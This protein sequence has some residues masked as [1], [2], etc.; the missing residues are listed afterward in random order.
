MSERVDYYTQRGS[1]AQTPNNWNPYQPL[2]M[3]VVLLVGIFLGSSLGKGDLFEFA[4]SDTQSNPSKLVEVI[5]RI[6]N[7]YVDSVQKRELIDNAINSILEDLD[8]HSFYISPEEFASMNE[9]MQGGFE[10]IGVEFMIED[11]TLIVVNPLTGGPSERAGILPGDRIVL[12]NDSAISGTDI[13]NAVVMKRLKGPSGSTVKLEIDRPGEVERYTF[14]IV[15]ERIPIHSVVAQFMENEEI[16]YIKITQFAA[17]TYEE[18]IGA[19][20]DLKE[21]GM[22]K[23]VIDLRSNGGGYLDAATNIVEEFLDKGE[24]IVYTEGRSQGRMSTYSKRKGRLRDVEVAVLMN[25][26]SASASEVVAGALQDHDRSI[27]V[28]RRSFG[29][30]LVQ[31]Q[32][33]MGDASALRIT[34]AR[35]Y[36]PSGRCIQKPYGDGIDYEDDYHQR[37]ESGELMHADS[38]QVTDSL[39][40]TT[41]GG[42]LVY[43]GGG[44][45]PD[46]FVAL[47]TTGSS[48]Y[49]GELS[50]AGVLRSFTLQYVNEHRADWSSTFPNM[51]AFDRG[52][53]ITPRIEAALDELA[54]A[55]DITPAP[56]TT[57]ARQEL[58]LR[59]KAL[60]AKHLF[61]ENAYYYVLRNRDR[62]YMKAVDVL[63]DYTTYFNESLARNQQ[64]S[65]PVN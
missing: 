40:Y 3:A 32:Y 7:H 29:K 59:L 18:F 53:T 38:I 34:V 15:R 48:T 65:H 49:L 28:G 64:S 5:E 24:L 51:E 8:P 16:G 63:H 6:E 57:D 50:Y 19:V 55:R 26:S 61:E 58:H 46:V 62:D 12:V 13:S 54:T 37:L 35:Y 45:I 25:Q 36:T 21:Q 31:H 1:S 2:L 43:G 56:L 4:P 22:K 33:Q 30:G 10:G 14:E 44:I 39:Q 60:M 42:R 27:T 11:D 23:L 9:Q 52:F 20:N 41:P 17:N 47:D